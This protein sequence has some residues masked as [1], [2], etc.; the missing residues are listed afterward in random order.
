V[1]S[2]AVTDVSEPYADTMLNVEVAIELVENGCDVEALPD[3]LLTR[4]N[5]YPEDLA[6]LEDLKSTVNEWLGAVSD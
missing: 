4:L 1:I 3:S 2:D 5:F 6:M